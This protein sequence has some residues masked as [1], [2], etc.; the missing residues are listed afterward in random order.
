M[1]D[2]TRLFLIRHGET[3]TASEFRYVG[4]MD[5]D[6][7]EN[8][9]EQMNKL[10]DRFKNEEINALY[11]SDLIRTKK[12]AKIISSCHPIKPV[13]LREFREINLG[14]WEGLTREEIIERYPMEFKQRLGNLANHR[15]KGGE[16]F[17]DLQERVVKKLLE[18]LNLSKGKNVMLVAHGGVNRAILFD[19]L[20]LDLG[21]LTRIDQVYGCLNIIDYYD[22]GPVIK[23]V[24]G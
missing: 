7:T 2:R 3:T 1:E 15:I 18:I 21:L 14:I 16:S 11:S 8:G 20:N 24:N 13:A 19:I 23:L 10:K 6:I 12:G 9:I 17:K 22:D 4:H 5:V